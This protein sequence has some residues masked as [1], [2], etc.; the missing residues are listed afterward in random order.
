MKTRVL[1]VDDD[2]QFVDALS[3]PL[4]LRDYEI[5]TSLNGKDALEKIRQYNYDVVIL[6]A[7]PCRV[8]TE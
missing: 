7:W 2:E 1:L 5:T 8:L 6:D 4:A 3:E